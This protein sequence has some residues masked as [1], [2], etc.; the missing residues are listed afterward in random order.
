MVTE[1]NIIFK[2]DRRSHIKR[3]NKQVFSRVLQSKT[4]ETWKRQEVVS[5]FT[6]TIAK[7]VIVDY[8]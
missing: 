6:D 8:H 4:R 1:P 3:M 7:N 5:M 2:A